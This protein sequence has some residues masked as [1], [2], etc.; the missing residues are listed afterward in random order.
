MA[1]VN[2]NKI[3]AVA[4]TQVSAINTTIALGPTTDTTRPTLYDPVWGYFL[5][6][7]SQGF[8][9]KEDHTYLSAATFTIQGVFTADAEGVDGAS[10]DSAFV[11]IVAKYTALE[12]LFAN[13]TK[14]E[15]PSSYPQWFTVDDPRVLPLPKPLLD[16]SGAVIYAKPVSLRIE[17]TQFPFEIRYMATLQEAKLP[18]AKL[19]INNVVVDGGVVQVSVPAPELAMHTI[20]GTSG[21]I[22]QVKHYKAAEYQ[23]TGSLPLIENGVMVTDDIKSL[24]ASLDAGVL[25]KAGVVTL[26]LYVRATTGMTLKTLGNLDVV[27]SPTVDMDYGNQVAQLRISARE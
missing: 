22:F 5:F 17:R 8:Q 10:D 18:K 19:V 6:G 14:A 15:A 27:D 1:V 25:T 13:A 20:V 16:A 7:Q 21:A 26:G 24:V 23:I 9:I 12:T 11:A 4:P 3:N 2:F